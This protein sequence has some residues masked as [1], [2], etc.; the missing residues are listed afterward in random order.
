MLLVVG[1][2]GV[3]LGFWSLVGLWLTTLFS[4]L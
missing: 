3:L 1:S 4:G 2:L